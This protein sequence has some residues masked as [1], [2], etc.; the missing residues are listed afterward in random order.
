MI[1]K[2]YYIIEG[3]KETTAKNRNEAEAKFDSRVKDTMLAYCPNATCEVT[4]IV[5]EEKDAG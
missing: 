3:Y 4:K 5:G 2:V 1:Y